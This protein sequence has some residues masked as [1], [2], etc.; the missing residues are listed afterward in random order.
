MLRSFDR[1]YEKKKKK[2][3]KTGRP[4]AHANC[5]FEKFLHT[6]GRDGFGREGTSL[7]LCPVGQLLSND[8][9]AKAPLCPLSL[10]SLMLMASDAVIDRSMSRDKSFRGHWWSCHSHTLTTACLVLLQFP[11]SVS[12]SLSIVLLLSP[13]LS[14]W[15]HSNNSRAGHINMNASD[16]LMDWYSWVRA[17]DN[18]I[19]RVIKLH[20]SLPGELRVSTWVDETKKKRCSVFW[21][22]P[23]VIDSQV[24]VQ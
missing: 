23:R 15:L 14:F 19:P 8:R 13:S 17:L 16:W 4:F 1:F 10:R 21:F 20:R 18:L 22:L 6:R 7:P 5:S 11:V 2:E 24:N 12:C 9:W 3:R